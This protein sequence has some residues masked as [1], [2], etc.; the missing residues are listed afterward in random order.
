MVRLVIKVAPMVF[1]CLSNA[2]AT[3]EAAWPGS[4]PGS[5]GAISEASSR[6]LLPFGQAVGESLG[7]P[8]RQ[9]TDALSVDPSELALKRSRLISYDFVQTMIQLDA[10]HPRRVRLVLPPSGS[11]FDQI[12]LYSLT[13]AGYDAGTDRY[14]A[15]D[16][17]RS[18][19]AGSTVDG[20]TRSQTFTDG[21]KVAGDVGGVAGNTDGL[22]LDV[23][24]VLP[25]DPISDL[26]RV[27]DP[28]FSRPERL[29]VQNGST[30]EPGHSIGSASHGGAG[31]D[32]S[33][34]L[35]QMTLITRTVAEP[36]LTANGESE[37]GIYSFFVLATSPSTPD[38]RMVRIYRVNGEAVLPVSVMRVE[39]ADARHLQADDEVF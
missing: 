22:P 19:G 13:L 20:G 33:Q 31:T 9:R 6:A 39:G 4:A 15:T 16:T 32:S 35:R 5:S 28:L 29:P 11:R 30:S 23:D 1:A 14:R 3:P 18:T 38:I 7:N 17:H 37:A 21:I 26:P 8:L 27:I 12:L 24:E 34:I 25:M 2:C 36:P 10:L